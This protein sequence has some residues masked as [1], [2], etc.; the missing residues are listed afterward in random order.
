MTARPDHRAPGHL[1]IRPVTGLPEFTTDS[2]VAGEILG[3]APWLESGDVL[4][5][6]S[7]IISKAEGRMVD[8]PSDPEERDALRRRLVDAE[9]VRVLAR[10]NRTLITE[11]RLGLVQ[12]AAGIDG[13]NVRSDQLAL[14]PENP[15]RSAA[16]LRRAIADAAGLD[17]AVIITDTMGRAWRTGQTDV[18]IGAAGIAVTHP[19]E[20]GVDDYGNPLIVTEIAVADELAAAADL[21]KGKLAAVPVA[22]VRGFAPADD[23]TT[24][25]DLIRPYDEDLFRLG[26]EEA[27][28]EGRREAIR[29]RRSVR[30]FADR[31]VDPAEMRDALAEALT[32][33]APHHTHPV[34]FVW[35]RS[36]SRRR[37]LL[38]AMTRDWRTDL[39]SDSKTAESIEKR[40]RRGQ[41]LYD[42]PELVIPFLVPEG[43]HDYPDDRRN[44]AEHTMF[45]VAAGGAVATLLTALAVRDIGS[46]WVGST[47]FAAPTVRRVLDLDPSWEPLGAVAIGHPL[48][49]AGLRDPAPTAEWVVEL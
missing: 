6:T 47:I 34:R 2:D 14:L 27:I 20:G 13:S 17:V 11:N 38:D 35:L 44:A 21:V 36:A 25:A 22:V 5:V 10:K 12:A 33:P 24:A 46:C 45:T 7:K 29:T 40:L 8:A 49:P 9:S 3:A 1:E 37:E 16:S 42:A 43:A 28:A 15:D 41:I 19:Y 30:T 32:A 23:G 31:P 26:T 39:E 18:A 4:V 48:E